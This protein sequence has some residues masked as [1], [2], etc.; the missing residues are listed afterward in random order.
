MGR[1][2][3]AGD[4]AFGALLDGRLMPVAGI[5]PALA[6]AAGVASLWQPSVAL[7]GALAAGCLAA[8][9]LLWGKGRENGWGTPRLRVPEPGPEEGMWYLGTSREGMGQMWLSDDDMRRHVAI[10]G[11]CG[12]GKTE[13]MTSLAAN[14]LWRG[15]GCLFIDGKGDASFWPRMVALATSCGRREDLMA[16]NL[17]DMERGDGTFGPM[18]GHR[19]NPLAH[20]DGPA[21]ARVVSDMVGDGWTGEQKA[22]GQ[23]FLDALMT[24]LVALRPAG[25]L[26]LG[27][28]SSWLDPDHVTE[29]A[30]LVDGL[31]VPSHAAGPLRAY[32]ASLASDRDAARTRH[33][34][35]VAPLRDMLRGVLF[36]YG[37]VLCDGGG[38]VDLADVVGRRR[39]LVV[40][41]PSLGRSSRYAS[42]FGRM[43]L[44]S[45]DAALATLRPG[46]SIASGVA[47]FLAILD[48]IG[49]YALPYMA[50]LG[51]RA[52]AANVSLI[53][54]VQDMHGLR[55][56]IDL[57]PN[58][59]SLVRACMLMRVEDVDTARLAT[60][61]CRSACGL[62]ELVDQVT[63]RDVKGQREGQFLLFT[64]MGIE[65][66]EGFYA[67]PVALGDKR[68]LQVL[69]LHPDALVP[70]PRA[71]IGG[72][73]T[74]GGQA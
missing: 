3:G 6:A 62:G 4:T 69:G 9:R 49:H 36:R 13:L 11:T 10:V 46:P 48:E 8:R 61:L 51:A 44:S 72:T 19:L 21:L 42:A 56:L 57:S 30:S 68:A 20:G 47:P 71:D 39:I 54:G 5:L 41:M 32:L 38:D 1:H 28:L 60:V 33:E 14:A 53:H 23:A 12:S 31:G 34:G 7:P 74:M 24:F 66:C 43:V 26:G 70:L 37:H 58:H 45:L 15:S 27:T 59:G 64:P 29:M 18:R 2:D 40:I 63:F 17:L 35:M 65:R 22:S 55:T 67:N 50:G 16:L 73:V 25:G 52:R